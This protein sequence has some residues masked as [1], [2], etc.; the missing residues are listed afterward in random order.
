MNG[1]VEERVGFDIPLF[2]T[3]ELKRNGKEYLYV[4]TQG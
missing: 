1:G 4:E 2:A 3:V